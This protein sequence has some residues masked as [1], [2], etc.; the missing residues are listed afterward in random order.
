MPD[1]VID[2]SPSST[3]S[4]EPA[5]SPSPDSAAPASSPAAEPSQDNS[6]QSAKETMLDAVLKVVPA[7]NE[8]DDIR[9]PN[10]PASPDTPKDKAED[11]QAEAEPDDGDDDD[12]EPDAHAA[13]PVIRKKINKL[14]KQRRELRETVNQLQT[15]RQPAEIGSQ[16]EGFA[17][18]NDLSADDIV[19]GLG[20]M[21]A[22]RRGDWQAFYDGIAKPMRQAQ[23]YLGHAIP[24]DLRQQVAQ[25]QMTEATARQMAR[26][27]MD[28]QLSQVTQ[29]AEQTRSAQRTLALTQDSVTRSVSAF[30][31][32][33]AASDPDYARKA[34][35]VKRV[36][37]A[38]LQERGG[39]IANAEEALEITKQAYDEVNRAIRKLQ[40]APHA[41]GRQPNGNGQTRQAR[42][43]PT[44]LMEAALQGL[45]RSRNGAA[46]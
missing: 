45:D 5:S 26:M 35:F 42:A 20:I 14:L 12:A 3:P 36:A 15:L 24:A 39:F 22:L 19:K 7:T 11:G 41:T 17:Q 28:Q 1:D 29:Q 10:A 21:A 33:L 44:S 9:D 38:K 25:G 31:G 34:D 30:E 2:T 23:E 43:E 13:S 6:G 37:Q 46:P 8:S 4:S 16:L 27:R 40:P 18:Q 32:Q